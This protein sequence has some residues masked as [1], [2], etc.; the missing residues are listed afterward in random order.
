M[1]DSKKSKG[2]NSSALP[3]LDPVS[4]TARVGVTSTD[5]A[6]TDRTQ[7]DNGAT[8]SR[9]GEQLRPFHFKPGQSGNPK[10]RPKGSKQK[11]G[12]DFISAL[13]EDFEAHGVTAIQEVRETKPA[14]YLKVIAGILPNELNITKTTVEELSDDDLARALATLQSVIA[15]EAT[16]TGSDEKTKH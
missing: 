6:S 10:G 15:A 13:Q 7:A 2:K 11:L 3:V 16:R 9:V 5:E 12:E 14:D 1:D 8:A 4:A